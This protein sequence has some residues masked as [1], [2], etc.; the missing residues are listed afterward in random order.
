MSGQHYSANVA[1]GPIFRRRILV[2]RL[3]SDEY[4]GDATGATIRSNGL[5]ISTHH[6]MYFPQI[7]CF[8]LNTETRFTLR[9]P[10]EYRQRKDIHFHLV[11]VHHIVIPVDWI[12]HLSVSIRNEVVFSSRKA[13]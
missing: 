12:G 5:R 7:W 4:V 11:L 1:D 8:R 3:A 6:Q 13:N 10:V 9:A 2:V